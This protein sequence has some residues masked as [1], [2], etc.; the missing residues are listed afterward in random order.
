VAGPSR[1]RFPLHSALSTV[2]FLVRRTSQSVAPRNAMHVRK[3]DARRFTLAATDF[4]SVVQKT[5]T[6]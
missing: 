1:S 2:E 6:D 4:Q 5:A 3:V